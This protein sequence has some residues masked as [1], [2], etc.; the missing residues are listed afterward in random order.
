MQIARFVLHHLLGSVIR[1]KR[2]DKIIDEIVL[3]ILS[4]NI[5]YDETKH[6]GKETK[7]DLVKEKIKHIER[8]M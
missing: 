2:V 6:E 4:K 1:L 5:Q 8:H 3:M 7:L